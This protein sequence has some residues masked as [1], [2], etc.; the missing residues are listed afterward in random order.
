M[1]VSTPFPVI[2]GIYLLSFIFIFLWLFFSIDRAEIIDSFFWQFLWASAFVQFINYFVA[3]H[4]AGMLIAFS[5]FARRYLRLQKNALLKFMSNLI[6]TLIVITCLYIFTHE[7]LY[8]IVRLQAEELHSMSTMSNELYKQAGQKKASGD[9][10]TALVYIDFSLA[11]DKNNPNKINEKLNIINNLSPDELHIYERLTTSDTRTTLFDAEDVQGLL[12][13]AE[14]AYFTDKDYVRAY[15]YAESVLTLDSSNKRAMWISNIAWE[16]I[17]ARKVDPAIEKA[18]YLISEKRRG[19]EAFSREDFIEAYYIFKALDKQYPHDP[20]IEFYLNDILHKL[21]DVSFFSDEAE[22]VLSLPVI[23]DDYF[24]FLN[25]KDE[26]TREIISVDSM[27]RV[28]DEMFF[29]NIEVFGFLKQGTIL[30]HYI[31]PYGKLNNDYININGIHREDNSRQT[32]TQ[33]LR[34]VPPVDKLK[35]IKLNVDPLDFSYYKIT[36]ADLQAMSIWQLVKTM[37]ILNDY[38]NYQRVLF[39]ELLLKISM[40]ILLLVFS[41]VC[42]RI[43]ITQSADYIANPPRILYL[44]LPIIPFLALFIVDMVIYLYKII[45][46]FLYFSFGGVFTVLVLLAAHIFVITVLFF[47]ISRRLYKQTAG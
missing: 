24:V 31:V 39:L 40:P 45:T 36:T 29:K 10:K 44:F 18:R 43:A 47:N 35:G 16:E 7:I 28:A 33:Y 46:G 14:T 15:T 41:L 17:S 34:G 30:Y 23:G 8:P 9:Y 3:V 42:A 20:Y 38:A 37:G 32:V 4:C 27:A 5:L 19:Y 2:V 21:P 1:N 11:I 12:Q 22:L 25:S 6:L 26:S 13:K